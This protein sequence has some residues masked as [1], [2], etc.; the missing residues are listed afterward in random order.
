MDKYGLFLVVRRNVFGPC[1]SQIQHDN[2]L[3]ISKEREAGQ[4]A[5]P[6]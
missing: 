1:G 2:D 6:N 4:E 5:E 3:K